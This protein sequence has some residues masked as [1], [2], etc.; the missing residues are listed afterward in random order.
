[1]GESIAEFS[2]FSVV[3]YPSLSIYC[4]LESGAKTYNTDSIIGAAAAFL[5]LIT[6]DDKRFEGDAFFDIK[7]ANAD[8]AADFMGGKGGV[9]ET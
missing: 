9:V 5:L 1:M 6:T 3:L 7:G 2:D 4:F 8:R